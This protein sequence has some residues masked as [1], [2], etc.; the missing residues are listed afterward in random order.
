MFA[1]I[2]DDGSGTCA[3]SSE[4]SQSPWNKSGGMLWLSCLMSKNDKAQSMM[5]ISD[6]TFDQYEI[7]KDQNKNQKAIDYVEQHGVQVYNQIVKRLMPLKVAQMTLASHI[8]SMGKSSSNVH[9]LPFW[10]NYVPGLEKKM[11]TSNALQLGHQ[12][13]FSSSEGNS[14][15][16][17][18][19]MQ[20][21]IN[22]SLLCPILIMFVCLFRQVA[23]A[24][25]GSKYTYD[26]SKALKA[27]EKVRKL[28]SKL[29]SE[30]MTRM[31]AGAHISVHTRQS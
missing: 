16:I 20:V 23:A 15:A 7:P 9:L 13:N 24:I 6:F 2:G 31:N 3:F 14:Q 12:W 22:T 29:R 11:D 25:P 8:H 28:I 26:P 21:H 17:D 10:A 30:W 4:F 5:Q 18:A 19:I 1:R 27:K